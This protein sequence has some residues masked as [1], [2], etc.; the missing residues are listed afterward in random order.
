[1]GYPTINRDFVGDGR[2]NLSRRTQ[3]IKWIVVHYTGTT[4]AAANNCRYFAGGN[5]GA[6]ADWFIDDTGIYAFNP[7]IHNYYSWHCGGGTAIEDRVNSR[8][9][10]IEVVSAGS[11]F[12][13]KQKDSLRSLVRALMSEFGIDANH[14][15]RHYDCHT[16]RKACPWPYTP[17]GGDP[18][19]KKWNELKAYIT[20]EEDDMPAPKDLWDYKTGT[21]NVR[22]QDRLVG[23]DN[24]ANA[25]NARTELL[26]KELLRTDDPTGDNTTGSLYTRIAWMDKRLRSQEKAL[27]SIEA[28]IDKLIKG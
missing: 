27:A 10:G 6:S 21:N 26:Q 8:A 1:M 7:N 20:Q 14:V 4:A 25:A 23:I 3:N 9:V 13:Q 2:F 17:N 22:A 24:A 12:T 18:S 16:G 19:G 5:R 11:D 15:I 28:K